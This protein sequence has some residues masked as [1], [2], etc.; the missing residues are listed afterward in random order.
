[1]TG[2][3]PGVVVEST[4]AA[5]EADGF[6]SAARP[7]NSP[8]KGIRIRPRG[9]RRR[10]PTEFWRIVRNPATPRRVLAS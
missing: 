8:S 2:S 1:M 6:E 4:V 9:A 5:S 3:E 7:D 10:L